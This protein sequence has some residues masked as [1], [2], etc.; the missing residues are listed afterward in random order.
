MFQYQKEHRTRGFQQR[1]KREVEG[2]N[3]V[4]RAEKGNVAFKEH[5]HKILEKIKHKA[6]FR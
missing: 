6:Y 4:S 1:P 2:Q 3:L 5:V